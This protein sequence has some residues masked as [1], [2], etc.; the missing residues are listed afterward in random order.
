M[1]ATGLRAPGGSPPWMGQF[2]SD[3]VRVLVEFDRGGE[4]RRLPVY[5]DIAGAPNAADWQGAIAMVED[6]GLGNPGLIW[7]D[8]SSWTGV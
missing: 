6:D 8:G 1:R 3:L 2:V 4:P 7:S 5:A